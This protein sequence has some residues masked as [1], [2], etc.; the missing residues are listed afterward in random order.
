MSPSEAVSML[1]H[2]VSTDRSR[3]VLLL[4]LSSVL[5]GCWSIVFRSAEQLSTTPL[6]A[7]RQT[8]VV[9]AVQLLLLVPLARRATRASPTTKTKTTTTTTTAGADR[10]WFASLG[11]CDALNAMSFFASMQRTSVAVAVLCH[12]AAPLIVAALAPVVLREPRRAGTW[13]ALA[14]AVAGVVVVLSPW[15]HVSARDVEGAGL[16]LVSA[17]FYAASVFIGKHLL[18][19]RSTIEVAA[20][21]KWA[22][23][24]VTVAGAV[25]FTGGVHVELGPLALLGVGSAVCGALALLT[26]YRGLSL[27]PASQASVLTLVEPLTAVIVGVVVWHEPLTPGI[28]VGGLLVAFAVVRVTRA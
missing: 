27:L 26:F 13:S 18:A 3:G 16:A 8:A 24:A 10:F 6:P 12:Y 4:V 11:V 28:V 1:P 17:G 14:V 5:W 21:P 25:G 15:S 20:Y 2:H 22:A 23:V 9:M 7:A 19:R